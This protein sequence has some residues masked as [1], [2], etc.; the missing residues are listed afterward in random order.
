MGC[1]GGTPAGAGSRRLLEGVDSVGVKLFSRSLR[2]PE[3]DDSD[4]T[5]NQNDP[6]L[7]P[8]GSVGPDQLVNPGDPDGV[9]VP[10]GG[11]HSAI[12]RRS[13]RRL[14]SGYPSS[15]YPPLWGNH[16]RSLTDTAWT[17]VDLNASLL[18]TMPPYLVN[19]AP[20][21]TPAGS[22]TRNRR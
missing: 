2:P 6:A 3:Y 12:C 15:W 21:L 11:H 16:A 19:A 17:C 18:A 20:T 7:N 9:E 10:D 13:C 22:S 4:I 14:W 1:A 8:P 5:P